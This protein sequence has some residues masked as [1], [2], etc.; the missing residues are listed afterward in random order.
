MLKK[1]CLILLFLPFGFAIPAQ[2]STKIEPLLK[3]MQFKQVIETILQESRVYGAT[4]DKQML[5][6]RGGEKWQNLLGEIYDEDRIWNAFISKLETELSGQ[7]TAAM[8]EFWKTDLGQRIV[9]LEN[10]GRIA[11]ADDDIEQDSRARFRE[12]VQN[13]H[14]R[15]AML[16]EFVAAGDFFEVNLSNAMDANY[17]F[18][19]GMVQSGVFDREITEEEILRN[20]W[21]NE[22]EIRKDIREWIYAFLALAFQPLTDAEL[23]AY[24]DFSN[25]KAGRVLNNAQFVAYNYVFKTISK[26][27]GVSVGEFLRSSDL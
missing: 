16:R 9:V 18:M 7:D 8:L 6:G 23:Q 3:A 1:I 15:V 26:A 13:N 21:E 19:S 14:P 5:Q 10:S 17:A 24:I 12:M 11:F 27:L 22:A 20:T 25:T 2:D 4:L